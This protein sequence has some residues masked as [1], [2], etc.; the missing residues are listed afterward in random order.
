MP[1]LFYYKPTN[2]EKNHPFLPKQHTPNMLGENT[3]M[4]IVNHTKN[5]SWHTPPKIA[6]EKSLENNN[7]TTQFPAQ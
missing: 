7:P 6:R 4:G 1:K 5:I 3:R 2:E